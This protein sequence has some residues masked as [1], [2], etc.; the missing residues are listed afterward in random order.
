MSRPKVSF[1]NMKYGA[2]SQ[3]AGIEF[4]PLSP[5]FAPIMHDLYFDIS[6]DDLASNGLD[7]RSA[8][9]YRDEDAAEARLID[10]QESMRSQRPIGAYAVT[11][12]PDRVFSAGMGE[13]HG[14]AVF[15]R[16]SQHQSRLMSI[17]DRRETG[18]R[19]F[20]SWIDAEAP[21]HLNPDQVMKVGLGLAGYAG[22]SAVQIAV[23]QGL[24]HPSD[25]L[26]VVEHEINPKRHGFV[27]VGERKIT[28]EGNQ[29]DST[30]FQHDIK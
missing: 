14:V 2:T 7:P 5:G 8:N 10:I 24:K 29:Y 28:I 12:R 11:D 17:L 13:V 27:A 23:V 21:K 16:E 19:I 25:R 26:T 30:V 18:V 4:R 9:A 3:G 15:A 22:L 6:A 1:R 20:T